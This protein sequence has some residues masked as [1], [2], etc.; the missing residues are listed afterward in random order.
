MNI[1]WKSELL[2]LL[3][4]ARAKGAN[5]VEP[6]AAGESSVGSHHGVRNCD[7]GTAMVLGGTC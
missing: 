7:A 1:F 2:D 5:V 6:G 3:G 4:I